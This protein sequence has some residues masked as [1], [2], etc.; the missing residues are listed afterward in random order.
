MGLDHVRRVLVTQKSR[1]AKDAS[2]WQAVADARSTLGKLTAS[3]HRRYHIK[4]KRL[5]F[6]G[7]FL[8]LQHECSFEWVCNECQSGPDHVTCLENAAQLPPILS[9]LQTR[10]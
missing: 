1:T 9:A 7:D 2:L 4:T 6:S 10:N 8:F 5:E 3:D